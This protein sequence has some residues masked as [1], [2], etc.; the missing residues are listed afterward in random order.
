MASQK[1]V[2]HANKQ[3]QQ[4]QHKDEYQ[5]YSSFPNLASSKLLNAQNDSILQN[6]KLRHERLIGQLKAAEARNR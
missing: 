2:Q 3:Q 6:E 4:Q 5:M 1:R